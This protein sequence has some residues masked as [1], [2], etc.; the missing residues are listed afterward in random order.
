MEEIRCCQIDGFASVWIF[1]RGP[2]Y[3]VC[4]FTDLEMAPC[5]DVVDYSFFLDPRGEGA[6]QSGGQSH[7]GDQI[8]REGGEVV[9]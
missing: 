1:G 4:V 2:Q 7:E 9:G 5:V 8:V 6:D 3:T